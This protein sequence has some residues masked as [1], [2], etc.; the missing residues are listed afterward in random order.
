V[1]ADLAH[2][3]ERLAGLGVPTLTPG[4]GRGNPPP[5]KPAR[6]RKA[7]L[8]SAAAVVVIAAVAVA[9]TLLLTGGDDKPGTPGNVKVTAGR[10]TVTVSWAP[11]SGKTDHYAVYRD[12]KLVASKV[13]GTTY[14]DKL[15]DTTKHSYAVRAVNASG[16]TSNPSPLVIMAA[17]VRPLNAAET[18]LINTL[19][20]TLVYDV[21]CKPL[22]SGVD[23]RLNVAV[24]CDPGPGQSPSPPGRVPQV[25]E[26]YGASNAD[27]L[28]A[29]LNNEI[30]THGAK[31]GSCS[32]VP[33]EGTWNFTETPKVI[34]GKII[35]YTVGTRSYLI[36]SYTA[37]DMYVRV[38]TTSSY[39]SLIK[40]WQGASLHLP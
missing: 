5:P 19:P 24:T 7:L 2:E 20:S 33:Q 34:N 28:N 36:W 27:N 31:S 17:D 30:T 40:W 8:L 32:A 23:S 9:L 3:V 10:G 15:S 38:S 35:C 4:D 26:V 1:L 39:A 21:T 13:T 29:V 22:L 14:L 25:V 6:K 11:G 12:G 16:N 37:Q 18:R